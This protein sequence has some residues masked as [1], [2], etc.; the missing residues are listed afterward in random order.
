MCV[1]LKLHN[2][3]ASFYVILSFKKSAQAEPVGNESNK[4]FYTPVWFRI[5]SFVLT[6]SVF[7]PFGCVYENPSSVSCEN[8]HHTLLCAAA[9][10]LC[11]PGSLIENIITF[12]LVPTATTA[13]LQCWVSS[14]VSRVRMEEILHFLFLILNEKL[15]WDIGSPAEEIKMCVTS[16][17]FPAKKIWRKLGRKYAAFLKPNVSCGSCS[18]VTQFINF[19]GCISIEYSSKTQVMLLLKE[20]TTAELF[21]H[22][23]TDLLSGISKLDLTVDNKFTL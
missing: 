23:W 15:S 21:N 14:N 7:T 6:Y 8:L 5:Y 20:K 19:L 10:F 16:L 2:A 3:W 1:R 13:I 12:W 22:E 17:F 4:A 11:E 18:I 9:V